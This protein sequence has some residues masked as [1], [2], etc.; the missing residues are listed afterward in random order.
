MEVA[1]IVV[2]CVLITTSILVAVTELKVRRSRNERYFKESKEPIQIID[3][4]VYNGGPGCYPDI[5]HI[6]L[7]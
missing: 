2:F 5:T 6:H 1:I 7:L 3:S 4:E